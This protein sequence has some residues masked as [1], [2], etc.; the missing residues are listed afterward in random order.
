MS[1]LNAETEQILL[2]HHP[3]RRK[4]KDEEL[5]KLARNYVADKN[6]E[7]Q[8]CGTAALSKETIY[9]SKEDT[10]RKRQGYGTLQ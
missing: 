10:Q 7:R 8:K 9:G 5:R 3:K 6:Q 2:L 4:V 1:V